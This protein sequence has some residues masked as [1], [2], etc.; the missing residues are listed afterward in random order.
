MNEPV[1]KTLIELARKNRTI[2]YEELSDQ[3]KL[4][5][6]M[7][8]SEF[9]RKEI[10]RIIGEVSTYEHRHGRPL[11]SSL[12]LTKGQTSKVM[13]FTNCVKHWVSEVGRN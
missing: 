7:Q 3:C 8:A 10:G 12:V 5:L 13:D 1:G 11:I 4:G 9:N 2:T 6:D